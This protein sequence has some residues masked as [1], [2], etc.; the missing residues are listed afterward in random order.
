MSECKE[1]KS[2]DRTGIPEKCRF[3]TNNDIFYR[4]RAGFKELRHI[5]RELHRLKSRKYISC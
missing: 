1:D 4:S 2:A 5:S 3:K